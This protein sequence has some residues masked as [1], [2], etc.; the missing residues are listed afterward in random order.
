MPH[1]HFTKPLVLLSESDELPP[2]PNRPQVALYS[3]TVPA[4]Q[5]G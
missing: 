3:G 1:L 4:P 2:V 5:L